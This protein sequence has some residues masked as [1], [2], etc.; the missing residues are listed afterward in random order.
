MAE[1]ASAD[2]T[3]TA[4]IGR[5]DAHRQIGSSDSAE[6][7]QAPGAWAQASRCKAESASGVHLHLG[8]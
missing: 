7:W 4:L 1:S 3:V 2:A 6:L 8:G 5:A